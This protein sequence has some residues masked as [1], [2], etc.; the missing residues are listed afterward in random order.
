MEI[1]TPVTSL[2]GKRLNQLDDRNMALNNWIEQLA[3]HYKRSMLPLHQ[4]RINKQYYAHWEHL[5]KRDISC[6]QQL[7]NIGDS[8]GIWTHD[9]LIEGEVL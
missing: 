5:L 2:K 6:L 1:W 3:L 9:T 7:H 4:S 8:G